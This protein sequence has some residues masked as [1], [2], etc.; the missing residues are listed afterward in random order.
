M[1]PVKFCLGVD[2]EGCGALFAPAR[3]DRGRCP[4]CRAKHNKARYDSRRAQG[5]LTRQWTDTAKRFLEA[6][7]V[8]AD[9]GAR[10]AIAHHLGRLRPHFAG[11]DEPGQPRPVVPVLSREAPCDTGGRLMAMRWCSKRCRWRRDR[12]VRHEAA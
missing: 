5:Y 9:C 11:R 6:N 12:R 7:P 2:G 1:S 8:C 3:D 10:S 4:K